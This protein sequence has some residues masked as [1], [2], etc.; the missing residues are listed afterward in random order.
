MISL[1]EG[2]TSPLYQQVYQQ[3][4]QEIQ[5]GAIPVG[6]KLPSKRKL[7]ELLNISINTVENAYTQLEAEGFIAASPRRGFYVLETGL[8]PPP[9]APLPGA[10]RQAG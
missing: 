3:F 8:L 4:R 6:E 10:C 7:S 2:S 1:P 9:A 5:S